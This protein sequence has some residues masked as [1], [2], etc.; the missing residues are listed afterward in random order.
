M[1][2]RMP[3]LKKIFI[4]F[5]GLL[6]F[7]TGCNTGKMFYD[8]GDELVSWQLDHYFDLTS[9]QEEWIEER[10]KLHLEWHR[11]EELPRYMRFLIDV[12]NSARD[13]LTMSELDEGYARIDQKRMRTLNRLIPDAASF[14]ATVSPEQINTLEK[15]MIEENEDMKEELDSP[16]KHSRKRRERFW[17][18]MEDWFGD[19]S[20]EQ[21]QKINRLQTKWFAGAADP[22]TVR[23]ERR[24][25][26]QP[27]F[28]ALLRSSPK[29]KDLEN[30]LSRSVNNWGGE[31]DAEKQAR[32]LRN[33][34]RI[35]DVDKVLTPEQRHHAVRELDEWIEFL[36]KTI[37]QE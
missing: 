11:K 8:Y 16:E 15:R 25:K 31:T 6:F 22:L 26:T 1:Q 37:K 28:L 27:Q 9:Q 5:S 2:T 4:F 20:E 7:I 10:M 35:L 36:D 33:K 3:R 30:W 18:Q 13:G 21:R 14:L 12:Q 29:K 32:I 23:M 19:F 24:L 17:E 34:K